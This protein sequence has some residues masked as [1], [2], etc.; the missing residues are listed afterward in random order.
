MLTLGWRRLTA[1]SMITTDTFRFS[2]ISTISPPTYC[3]TA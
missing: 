1:S 3:M 2:F